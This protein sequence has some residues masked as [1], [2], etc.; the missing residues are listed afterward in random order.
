MSTIAS[1]PD[2]AAIKQRQQQTWASGDFSV[3]ATMIVFAA[4]RLV[5]NADLHAGWR[6]FRK[7]NHHLSELL[8]IR[9]SQAAREPPLAHAFSLG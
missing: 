3:V 2:L 6:V 8:Q 9:L 5:D 1:P 4:E 7:P